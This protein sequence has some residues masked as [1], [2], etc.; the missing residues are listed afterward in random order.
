MY[1]DKFN[2][3]FGMVFEDLLTELKIQHAIEKGPHT[4]EDTS[5]DEKADTTISGKERLLEF[6][7]EPDKLANKKVSE[8]N[9][10]NRLLKL[11][12]SKIEQ[13][14]KEEHKYAE[15]SFVSS[16]IKLIHLEK[17]KNEPENTLQSFH[18]EESFSKYYNLLY[19]IAKFYEYLENPVNTKIIEMADL[20][21]IQL[22]HLI[23]TTELYVNPKSMPS[24]MGTRN[25]DA[26][27]YLKKLCKE[28]MLMINTSSEDFYYLL[29]SIQL[30]VF[31]QLIV[32][33]RT[34]KVIVFRQVVSDLAMEC[35]EFC[36]QND[37]YKNGIRFCFKALKTSSPKNRQEVFNTLGLCLINSNQHQFAYDTYLSWI[38]KC[39]IGYLQ[40]HISDIIAELD[41]MLQSNEEEEWRQNNKEEVALIY[42]NFSYLCGKMYDLLGA[43]RIKEELYLLA[44][45]FIREASLIAENKPEYSCTLGTLCSLKERE[46]DAISSYQKYLHN[47]NKIHDIVCAE[48]SLITEYK[49]T[50][51]KIE[52]KDYEKLCEKFL[53]S[54]K[55]LSNYKNATA[56]L[57]L[58]RGSDLYY[59][60]TEC[61]S[62]S[63]KC[64]KLKYTLLKM[65]DLKNRILAN[66][67]WKV[68]IHREFNLQIDSLPEG[69]RQQLSDVI[70]GVDGTGETV[71]KIDEQI[72]RISYYAKLSDLKYIF[73]PQ[74]QENGIALNC[75]TMMHARYMNDPE[76]G[77]IL[78]QKLQ[79]Y[80]LK[81][82]EN[83]REELYD[84]K[85]VFLKS[86]TGL[87]DQINMWT[88][89]GSDRSD[90]NDC[91]GCCVII[92][93]ET[94]DS[95][96]NIED[97]SLLK[98]S[99]NENDDYSLYNIA[100]FNG[101]KIVVDGKED[102][103]ME[104]LFEEIKVLLTEINDELKDAQESD[105]KII[106]N[107][108]ARILEK[109]MFLFKDI[110]YSLEEESRLILTRDITASSEIHKTTQKPPKLL[111][112]PPF[113]IYPEKIIIGPKTENVDNW[114]PYLQYELSKIGEKWPFSSERA[115]RP[116]VRTSRINIR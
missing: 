67:R 29:L 66:L 21:E 91:N 73:E 1:E 111:I 8:M 62:L 26:S 17:I 104:H 109:P 55:E 38:C 51:D 49:G 13:L 9:D 103:K 89:Y 86:F 90:G 108:L 20:P 15:T 75:L 43:S 58:T 45:Y 94:F 102:E 32:E 61:S 30:C 99:I 74:Q 101:E 96:I 97:S 113:Q 33:D 81:T 105:T 44:E 82:P 39:T 116:T 84:Q 19:N 110:S 60:L 100:Y 14:K 59:L 31:I 93:P 68:Y 53:K 79:G 115:F 52:C 71:T 25:P 85:Y 87:I 12:N 37:D 11:V 54:Y 50:F 98:A 42:G 4:K 57:E 69:A 70:S 10:V 48:R 88:T 80:L 41:G 46:D 106:Y 47:S 76:E 63:E 65:D 92:A 23:R 40:K 77:L 18:Y 95:I 56:K 64:R 36:Y 16:L 107:C 24:V 27:G 78:L 28:Y 72:K 114:V 112:Y 35:A 6:V 7:S 22:F 83:M 3:A 5:P 34:D 2:A